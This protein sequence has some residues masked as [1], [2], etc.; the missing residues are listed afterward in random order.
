MNIMNLKKMEI[1]SAVIL[2][3]G[4]HG[5]L[6]PALLMEFRETV[7]GHFAMVRIGTNP[8]LVAIPINSTHTRSGYSKSTNYT[9]DYVV[10]SLLPI[11]K[12]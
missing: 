8:N 7:N 5:E 10:N 9:I 1:G 6:I 12:L 4:E 3:S 2:S 11:E